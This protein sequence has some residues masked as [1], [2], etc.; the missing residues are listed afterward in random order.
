MLEALSHITAELLRHLKIDRL[1]LAAHSAGIYQA[2]DLATRYSGLVET[3]FP[4]CSHVPAKLTNSN[5][6]TLL[7]QAPKALLDLVGRVDTM[8][9]PSYLRRFVG[10]PREIDDSLVVLQSRRKLLQAHRP[11]ADQVL[12][13]KRRRELDYALC[14]QHLAHYSGEDLLALYTNCPTPLQ[15][16][17]TIT[18]KFFGPSTVQKVLDL[19]NSSCSSI[20]RIDDA[21]HAD[22]FV[23]TKVWEFIFDTIC[24][25]GVDE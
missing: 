23:K 21:H 16:F 5:A 1:S 2:L 17:T 20:V 11:D 18:D 3:V 6:M 24:Q 22:I 4:M 14:Y 9:L 10:Q 25:G 15:W 13:Q 12:M 7:T 19:R 8:T